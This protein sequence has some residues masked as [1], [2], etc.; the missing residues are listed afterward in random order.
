[1]ITLQP[2][3]KINDARTNFPPVIKVNYKIVGR[4]DGD[5]A[6]CFADPSK[7][8]IILNWKATRGVN[9]MCRSYFNFLNQ[10]AILKQ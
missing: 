2:V 6:I 5:V 9:E 8:E 4:R 3:V 10:S 1:M 7:A